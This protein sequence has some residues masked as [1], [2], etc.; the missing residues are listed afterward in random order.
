ML[1]VFEKL[2]LKIYAQIIVSFRLR[3]HPDL[4]DEQQNTFLNGT[5]VIGSRILE[6]AYC[7]ASGSIQE[8]AF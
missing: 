4:F 5:D 1:L 7:L 8:T 6:I 2:V 3:N